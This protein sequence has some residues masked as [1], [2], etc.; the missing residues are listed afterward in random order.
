MAGK[1]ENAS[2]NLTV[3]EKHRLFKN[4]GIKS[5]DELEDAVLI[6]LKET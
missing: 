1:F 6:R 4:L 2:L 5:I 3:K